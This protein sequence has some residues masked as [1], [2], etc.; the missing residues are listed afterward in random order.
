MCVVVLFDTMVV[1]M[2]GLA[3]TF[4]SFCTQEMTM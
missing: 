4:A 1:S 2:D 3:M